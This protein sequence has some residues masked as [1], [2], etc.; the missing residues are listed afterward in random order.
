MKRMV[1][2]VASLLILIVGTVGQPTARG[3]DSLAPITALA[4]A[5]SGTEVVAGSQAGLE[6]RRIPHVVPGVLIPTIPHFELVRKLPTEL[7][8]IHDVRFSPDGNLLGVVGGSPSQHG[9]VELYRW[10]EAT[11]HS[12]RELHEDLNYS[13]GWQADS[14]SFAVAGF[15]TRVSICDINQKV[16]LR[17]IEGHSR[18]VLAVAFLPGEFGL[19]SGGVDESIRLWEPA[20]G[21]L[22]RSLSNHTKSVTGLAVRPGDWP[23]PPSLA[24]IGLDHTVRLWQP[25]IG[26]LMRFARLSSPPLDVSWMNDG[27]LI[28]VA[29]KDGKLRV[30]DPD[31]MEMLEEISA[32]DGIAYCLTVLPNGK[33]AVGGQAGQLTLQ[34][35]RSGR[36]GKGTNS[37]LS[38][39]E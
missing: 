6:L 29:C 9:A 1:L 38:K 21:K 5:P 18:S 20:T 39:V 7:E 4:V 23:G 3:V 12:R 33:V 31:S 2:D 14:K 35:P 27:N 11:L 15:D 19:A 36:G 10:P 37:A 24:S 8:H 26:R 22:L 13:I 16:P 28:V 32:I 17:V 30:I 25:T 34:T